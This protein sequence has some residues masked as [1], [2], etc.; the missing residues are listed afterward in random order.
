MT[1][2][3]YECEPDIVWERLDSVN[4]DTTY[5]TG[6]FTAFV[7]HRDPNAALTFSQVASGEG[8]LIAAG[9]NPHPS[10]LT[11]YDAAIAASLAAETGGDL[12][13]NPNFDPRYGGS[14]NGAGRQHPSH[15]ALTPEADH[16]DADFA[17]ALQLQ[18]QEEEAARAAAERQLQQQQPGG[19]IPQQ[20]PAQQQQ[21]SQQLQQQGESLAS[22]VRQMGRRIASG[23]ER[24]A[25]TIQQQAAQLAAPEYAGQQQ[26][27][28]VPAH[29]Q[30]RRT[31]VHA[32]G[33]GRRRQQQDE[34]CSIM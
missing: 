26:Q 31:A 19:R 16:E 25:T 7:P 34:K 6:A 29:G 2:Q 30:H 14:G 8:A 21:F 24:T 18:L 20:Q 15:P 12:H 17:L 9:Q 22:S 11:D 32:S 3:G 5:C 13:M 4:G 28:A 10:A 23:V 1:D 27:H 33:A